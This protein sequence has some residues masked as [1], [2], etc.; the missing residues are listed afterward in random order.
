MLYGFFLPALELITEENFN[1]NLE[2]WFEWGCASCRDV[3]LRLECLRLIRFGGMQF[4]HCASLL[5]VPE[6]QPP[7]LNES[8]D[9]RAL[10]PCNPWNGAVWGTEELGTTFSRYICVRVSSCPARE[11][12]LCSSGDGGPGGHCY[13][14][15]FSSSGG[16]SLQLDGPKLQLPDRDQIVNNAS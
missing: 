6:I 4:K 14:S 15:C 5:T 2:C 9:G 16:G 11:S 8:H 7:C 3:N 13:N 1:G 12:Q 10:S